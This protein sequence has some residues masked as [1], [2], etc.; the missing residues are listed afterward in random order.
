MHGVPKSLTRSSLD[1]EA[2][3][4]LYLSD[5]KCRVNGSPL[6]WPGALFCSLDHALPLPW[7]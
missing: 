4:S 3:V 5:V 6:A 1:L 7:L 2:W